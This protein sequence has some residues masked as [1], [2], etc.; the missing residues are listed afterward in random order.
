VPYDYSGRKRRYY[1]PIKI[2]EHGGLLRVVRE[3]MTYWT[4]QEFVDK[5]DLFNEYPFLEEIDHNRLK[6]EAIHG[7][8]QEH[9]GYYLHTDIPLPYCCYPIGCVLSAAMGATIH[10]D[11]RRAFE[12]QLPYWRIREYMVK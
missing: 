5:Y 6:F 12:K 8:K 3:P 11:W 10:W 7:I 4:K 2:L 9:F 1:D